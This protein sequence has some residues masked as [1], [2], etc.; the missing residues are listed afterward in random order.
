MYKLLFLFHIQLFKAEQVD[1]S[2]L[3]LA[4]DLVGCDIDLANYYDAGLMS[5]DCESGGTDP[6]HCD[7]DHVCCDVHQVYCGFDFMTLSL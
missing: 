1:R 4:V 6:M 3:A 7:V 5:C 2:L